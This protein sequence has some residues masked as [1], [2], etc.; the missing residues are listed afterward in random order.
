MSRLPQFLETHKKTA[1][2]LIYALT[3]LNKNQGCQLVGA[4]RGFPLATVVAGVF[5]GNS[6]EKLDT[7]HFKRLKDH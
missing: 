2:I 6:P 3:G 5:T 1:K 7:A 4:G